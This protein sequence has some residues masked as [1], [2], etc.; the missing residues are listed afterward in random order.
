MGPL[1][2][3]LAKPP[4]KLAVNV[5]DAATI[6]FRANGRLVVLLC[7]P[8]TCQVLEYARGGKR[9]ILATLP[10]GQHI[11]CEDT[12][13]KLVLILDHQAVFEMPKGRNEQWRLYSSA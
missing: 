9:R 11:A 2:F 7:T 13:E 4:C 1:P 12:G 3:A 5:V 10:G 6:G 8:K